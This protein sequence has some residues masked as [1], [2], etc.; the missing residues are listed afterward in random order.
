ML[1]VKKGRVEE[2]SEGKTSTLKAFEGETEGVKTK[3]ARCLRK[4]LVS[5]MLRSLNLQSIER[6]YFGIFQFLRPFI[7]VVS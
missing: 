6:A 3:R 7:S 5:F 1:A 4:S 2:G